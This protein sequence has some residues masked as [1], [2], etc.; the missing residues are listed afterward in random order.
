MQGLLFEETLKRKKHCKIEASVLC[1]SEYVTSV[2]CMSRSYNE[3]VRCWQA[4]D[5]QRR[6]KEAA[7]EAE[8]VDREEAEREAEEARIAAEDAEAAKWMRQFS[9][10]GEGADAAAT[11]E[12][13]QVMSSKSLAMNVGCLRLC[14]SIRRWLSSK[15][16]CAGS[17]G[18]FHPVH[19][20]PQV[21][22][23]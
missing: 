10:E 15:R 7:R 21:R 19:Q 16:T 14:C 18:N 4:Y 3:P 22:G 9:V 23:P 12:E 1:D 2:F 17:A 20:R 5:A 13:A 8:D 6:E 11:E